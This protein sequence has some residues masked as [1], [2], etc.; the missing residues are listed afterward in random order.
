MSIVAIMSTDSLFTLLVV[1]AQSLVTLC[2]SI[3]LVGP[4]SPVEPLPQET[5]A[6]RLSASA[7]P[8]GGRVGLFIYLQH[9]DCESA[10]GIVAMSSGLE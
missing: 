6:C 5:M 10:C 3:T 4:C 7:Q 1:D 8:V 9:N 2:P